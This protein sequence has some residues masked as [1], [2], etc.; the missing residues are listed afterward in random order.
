[1]NKLFDSKKVEKFFNILDRLDRT[2][3]KHYKGIDPLN[4]DSEPCQ[5]DIFVKRTVAKWFPSKCY[6]II[7]EV[8]IGFFEHTDYKMKRYA[9]INT[10]R[11]HFIYGHNNK[12]M[13]NFSYASNVGKMGSIEFDYHTALNFKAELITSERY[14]EISSLFEYNPEKLLD[15]Q[16]VEDLVNRAIVKGATTEIEDFNYADIHVWVD[17]EIKKIR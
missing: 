8:S 15:P 1:M 17:K 12:V 2:C 14:R 6:R 9:F 5:Q 3:Q 13:V 16:A 11:P 7:E 4:P 10:A